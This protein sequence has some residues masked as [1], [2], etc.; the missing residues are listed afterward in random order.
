MATS[1]GVATEWT[2]K[3]GLWT[4]AVWKRAVVSVLVAWVTSSVLRACSVA[5]VAC[6]FPVFLQTN[7][8]GGARDWRGQVREQHTDTG[9]RVTVAS[10]IFSVES[11]ENAAKSYVLHCVQVHRLID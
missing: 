7:W 11:T 9:L 3:D 4:T 6:R 8:S 1:R 10:D 5:A 2:S